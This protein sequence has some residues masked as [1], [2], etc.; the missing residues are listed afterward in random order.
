MRVVFST[1]FSVAVAMASR[2][3]FA[4]CH[5]SLRLRSESRFSRYMIDF[6]V[7]EQR[8]YRQPGRGGC[9][10]RLSIFPPPFVNRRTTA[11]TR[12]RDG[13]VTK[14]LVRCR[15]INKGIL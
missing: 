1:I 4:A 15:T 2:Y 6:C 3:A 13:R 5:A 8:L 14:S 9:S 7:T 11:T 10:M 12:L